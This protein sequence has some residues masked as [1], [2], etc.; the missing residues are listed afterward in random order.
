MAVD[1]SI[2]V[3]SEVQWVPE[4]CPLV[5]L[6]TVASEQ[7]SLCS[8]ILFR[9]RKVRPAP[10][11]YKVKACPT[12]VQGGQPAR[13]VL[14]Q[15]LGK[16]EIQAL[17]KRINSQAAED[18]PGPTAEQGGW[19]A[20]QPA[21]FLAWLAVALQGGLSADL[22]DSRVHH[23]FPVIEKWQEKFQRGH[24]RDILQH[25][26][27]KKE[28]E[29]E[30]WETFYS[31][32]GKISK[33]FQSLYSPGQKL[34][35]KKYALSCR[36][37]ATG[38]N[39]LRLALLCDLESGYICNFYLYSPARL[40][41]HSKCP[42][43]EQVLHHLLRLYYNKGYQV[44]MDGSAST[45]GS[46][47]KHFSSLGIQL[48][49]VSF[50]AGEETPVRPIR[51]SASQQWSAPAGPEEFA[52]SLS[53]HLRGWTG[54]VIFP[55]PP[56]SAESSS[57]VFLTGFWLVA[58]LGS[59]NAFVLST[60]L[61]QDHSS[62]VCL[63][64]FSTRLAAQLACEHFVSSP[65]SPASLSSSSCKPHFTEMPALSGECNSVNN[66]SGPVTWPEEAHPSTRP[67]LGLCGLVNSGNSCYLN[68]ALQC[69]SN[70]SPLV[71]YLLSDRNR[72]DILKLQGEVTCALVRFLSDVWSSR[73]E[74]L[75]PVE[76][77]AVVSN[78]HPQFNSLTQQDAQELLL[79]LL[80]GLHEELKNRGD[81]RPVRGGGRRR[82]SGTAAPVRGE[83]SII[84]LLFEGQLH[85]LTL[86][87]FCDHQ[88]QTSQVFTVLSLPIPAHVYKCSLQDCLELFFQ[89]N[90]LTCNNRMFCSQCGVK[91]DT[92]VLTTLARPPE[93]LI[94]HL[95]RFDCQGLKKKKLRTN[96]CFSLENLDLS[97]YLSASSG[98][99]A[100]YS[101]Y[102]VVNHSGDLDVGHYTACC[103]NPVTQNW[104]KYDDA[105]VSEI[106]DYFIQS[107]N[108]YILLYSC[109]QFQPPNIPEN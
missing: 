87:M 97:P 62:E 93:I 41:K 16:S 81:R 19:K 89:Q 76:M 54:P 58:H 108:A 77:R 5:E 73:R 36:G 13:E 71:E 10:E 27:G 51:L 18:S 85:Y 42:V 28:N 65:L 98:K 38:T 46:L 31:L 83:S 60:L 95:K 72:S 86:C 75:T 17:C 52:A 35:I 80:N 20:V 92:A 74:S 53:S 88:T 84:T 43:V 100:R 99:R 47:A 6:V 12:G 9:T 14:L 103:R 7:D 25:L 50:W 105:V 4:E 61:S 15:L 78:L 91:Q 3:V 107:P 57:A 101:L 34:C 104:H 79:Y 90:T 56:G 26:G 64:D 68:A 32:Q 33:N 39:S 48:H 94:L 29:E 55:R 8:Q 24:F 2:A 1:T 30:A 70:T 66:K 67:C 109:Q 49:F 69:L 44:H 59:I 45:E 106:P 11:G 21:D 22:R 23:S 102:G 82:D 96:V 63:Y 37:Q 40:S